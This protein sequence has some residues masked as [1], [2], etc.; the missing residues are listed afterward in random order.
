MELKIADLRW[1]CRFLW[2]TGFNPVGRNKPV[3]ATARTGVAYTDVDK[4]RE[5]ER[6]PFR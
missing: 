2:T 6:K 5:Q 1:I 4:G 3:R